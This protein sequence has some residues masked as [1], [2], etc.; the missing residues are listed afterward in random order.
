MGSTV[1]ERADSVLA[2]S[3]AAAPAYLRLHE[4]EAVGR[5][6]S[7]LALSRAACLPKVTRVGSSRAGR[8]H[9]TRGEWPQT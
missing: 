2:L 9:P 7:A 6:D 4:W 3:R 1:V 5:A 8:Q